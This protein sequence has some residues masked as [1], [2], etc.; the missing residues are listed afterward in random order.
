[1]CLFFKKFSMKENIAVIRENITEIAK[2]TAS[3]NP[4]LIT[5]SLEAM[6]EAVAKLEKSAQENEAERKEIAKSHAE[7]VKKYAELHT[8]A[9]NLP[10]LMKELVE[11]MKIQSGNIETIQK[12]LADLGA[13]QGSKQDK[14]E[15]ITKSATPLEQLGK[16]LFNM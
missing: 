8:Y 13:P 10:E 14:S 12:N 7:E 1:M 5:K 3:E 4:E 15:E 6:T 2:A 9:E 11:A 16:K